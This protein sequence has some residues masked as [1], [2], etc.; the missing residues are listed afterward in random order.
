MLI[1]DSG[2]GGLSVVKEIRQHCPNLS[3]TYLM[4]D[5]FFPY[6]TKSDE[7]LKARLICLCQ[8]AIKEFSPKL[9]LIACNTASTL[10][11]DELRELFKIPFVGVVPA[12]KVAAQQ[13][14][15]GKIGLLATP[16]T[17]RRDYIDGLIKDFAS[18]CEVRRFGSDKLVTWAEKYIQGEKP[19]QLQQHLN[20]WL[21]QPE[22][23]SHVVLGCTHFPL[24]KPL[25]KEY[26]PEIT[27]IDSGEAIAKRVQFLSKN[28]EQDTHPTAKLLWTSNQP[29]A[30]CIAE[31]IEQFLT[32]K[33]SRQLVL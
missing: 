1:I 5:G 33:E 25:L 27:W 24:L 14:K 6:G 31:Y 2:V 22:A 28:L 15:T 4:D 20:D 19:E 17:V 32:I 23:L 3:L 29:P 8:A 7:E 13:S 26:W 21:N 9:I 18:H 16:A 11:L 12:I 30:P 10:A